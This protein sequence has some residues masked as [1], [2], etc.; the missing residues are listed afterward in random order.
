M[1]VRESLELGTYQRVR[2]W[3]MPHVTAWVSV[4]LGGGRG[5]A[6]PGRV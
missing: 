5:A 6:I 4:C 1:G 2:A 3:Y